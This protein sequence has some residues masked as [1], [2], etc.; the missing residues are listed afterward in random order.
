MRRTFPGMS[1]A[2]AATA[3]NRAAP[4]SSL[5]RVKGAEGTSLE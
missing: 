4:F 5:R 1:A 3:A 2:A